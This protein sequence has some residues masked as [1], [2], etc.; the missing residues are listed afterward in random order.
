MF[1][2]CEFSLENGKLFI[3][4]FNE[5]ILKAKNEVNSFLVEKMLKKNSE[6][7]EKLNLCNTAQWL[8]EH[9]K[10]DWKPFP[11]YINSLIESGYLKNQQIVNSKLLNFKI[12][13]LIL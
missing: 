8:Y 6:I 4:G 11:L 5:E 10:D 2:N 1:E 12:F 9:K 7:E 3:Y 13:S